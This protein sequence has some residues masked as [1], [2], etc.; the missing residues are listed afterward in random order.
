MSNKIID[1]TLNGPLQI[2][3][4]NIQDISWQ[5]VINPPP[6][7]S[8]TRVIHTSEC[9]KSIEGKVFVIH[10]HDEGSK[11][12]VA[13]FISQIGL[14]PIILHEKPNS[15]KTIIE[16]FEQ[17]ATVAFAIALLTPDD[18]GKGNKGDEQLEYR[19]R[20]NV[21][22]EFGYF[23]GRLGRKRVCGLNLNPERTSYAW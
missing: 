1:S 4:K 21:L 6:N 13:R 12:A 9:D 10:G 11:E 14:S 8:K 7:I 3:M 2:G 22:F 17:Y 16:K 5:Q 18:I 15:G 20:Q 19:A 23:V